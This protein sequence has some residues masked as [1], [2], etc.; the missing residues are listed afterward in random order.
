MARRVRPGRSLLPAD[1]CCCDTCEPAACSSDAVSLGLPTCAIGRRAWSGDTGEV[2]A[3]QRQEPAQESS[4]R[5]VHAG[6]GVARAA[7][8]RKGAGSTPLAARSPT[9]G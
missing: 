2:T 1:A 6:A 8:L 5:T 9:I 7:S 4:L 3:D